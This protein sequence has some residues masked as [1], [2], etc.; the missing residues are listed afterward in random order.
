MQDEMS[1][2]CNLSLPKATRVGNFPSSFLNRAQLGLA[3]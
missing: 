2:L 3:N 1:D